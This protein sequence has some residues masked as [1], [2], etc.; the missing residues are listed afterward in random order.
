MGPPVSRVLAT[1]FAMQP[2]VFLVWCPELTGYNAQQGP[3]HEYRTD[4]H[5][6]YMMYSR[7]P[8][9]AQVPTGSHTVAT[10]LAV[11]PSQC[12]LVSCPEFE[13][14]PGKRG[15]HRLL[16]TGAGRSGCVTALGICA[17]LPCSSHG[18]PHEQELGQ[19]RSQ[20]KG[21]GALALMVIPCCD[22]PRVRA[23]G[24]VVAANQSWCGAVSCQ[25]RAGVC[26]TWHRLADVPVV[27]RARNSVRYEDMHAGGRSSLTL[28]RLTRAAVPLMH[29]IKKSQ[30]DGIL[31]AVVTF[32]KVLRDMASPCNTALVCSSIHTVARVPRILKLENLPSKRRQR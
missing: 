16:P 18:T 12:W 2:T 26:S 4:V 7:T 27:Y 11:L 21:C 13:R 29:D 14:K 31:N 19:R 3:A 8:S 30:F 6:I 10:T 20:D 23:W 17:Q 5:D 28:C 25:P 24:V 22:S 9:T 1:T 32:M 15:W